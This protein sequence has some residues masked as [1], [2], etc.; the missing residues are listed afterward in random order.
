MYFNLPVEPVL[1]I[2]TVGDCL[3]KMAMVLL[4]EETPLHNSMREIFMYG[5]VRMK[6]LGGFHNIVLIENYEISLIVFY[7]YINFVKSIFYLSY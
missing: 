3:A 1:C 4:I 5:S 2:F 6:C 7:L